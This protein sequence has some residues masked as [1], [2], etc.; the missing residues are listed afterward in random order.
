MTGSTWTNIGDIASGKIGFGMKF[1]KDSN[2][3]FF[4]FGIAPFG[5]V[6]ST[7]NPHVSAV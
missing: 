5:P 6:N 3:C 2:S 7:P 1:I 4:A